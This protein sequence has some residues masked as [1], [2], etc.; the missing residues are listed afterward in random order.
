MFA[1]LPEALREMVLK[2]LQDDDFP[3]A[4]KLYDTYHAQHEQDEPT[5]NPIH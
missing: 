2:F 3:A 4:K 5:E 1:D